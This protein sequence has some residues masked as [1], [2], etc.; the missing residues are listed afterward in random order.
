MVTTEDANK[1]VHEVLTN[2]P[3]WEN[4]VGQFSFCDLT[5][6]TNYK[7]ENRVKNADVRQAIKENQYQERHKKV[8][9]QLLKTA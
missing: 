2:H 9:E 5:N 6:D 1:I 7:M 8:M 3:E 4:Y